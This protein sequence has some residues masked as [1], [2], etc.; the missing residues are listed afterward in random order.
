MQGDYTYLD[1]IQKLCSIHEHPSIK[2]L[3]KGFFLLSHMYSHHS[4]SAKSVS[5]NGRICVFGHVCVEKLPKK[6]SPE[7]PQSP[8][9]S[10]YLSDCLHIV[11]LSISSYSDASE[12]LSTFS[13]PSIS[14]FHWTATLFPPSAVYAPNRSIQS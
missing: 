5:K 12:A 11:C 13:R 14:L 3:Y 6:R 8:W 9:T 7:R 4:H 1:L 2:R 10:Y